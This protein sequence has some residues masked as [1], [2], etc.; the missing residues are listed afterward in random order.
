MQSMVEGQGA[1]PKNVPPSPR[2]D[3]ESIAGRWDGRKFGDEAY[4]GP[5]PR[6]G[7]G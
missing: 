5:D 6:S 4:I 3:P 1:P 7:R 2:L